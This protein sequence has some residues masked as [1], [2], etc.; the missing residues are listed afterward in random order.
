MNAALT[1]AAAASVAAKAAVSLVEEAAAAVSVA[2]KAA[3]GLS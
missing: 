3:A 2:A 1:E